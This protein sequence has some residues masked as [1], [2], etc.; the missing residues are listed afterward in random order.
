MCVASALDFD[1]VQKLLRKVVEQG[2][3]FLGE[4][5]CASLGEFCF[6]HTLNSLRNRLVS[7]V[8]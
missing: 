5:S 2:N 1:R 8:S 3:L 6:P 7:Q 4:N